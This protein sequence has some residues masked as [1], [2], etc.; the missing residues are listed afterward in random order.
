MNQSIVSDFISEIKQRKS[1]LDIYDIR[2][3]QWLVEIEFLTPI[4]YH[5]RFRKQNINYNAITA[6]DIAQYTFC[7]ASF[8]IQKSFDL[9]PTPKTKVGSKLH[10]ELR[11]INYL[12]SGVAHKSMTDTVNYHRD[13][14]DLIKHS[15]LIYSGHDDSTR[16]QVF[17]KRN[18]YAQPDYIFHSPDNGFFIVEEKYTHASNIDTWDR[19]FNFNNHLMQVAA[20]LYGIEEYQANNGYVLNWLY[21]S[22]DGEH[23]PEP[24]ITGCRIHKVE[25]SDILR[26]KLVNT[27]YNIKAILTHKEQQFDNVNTNKCRSCSVAGIC[28]HKYGKNRTVRIPYDIEVNNAVIGLPNDLYSYTEDIN[29][30]LSEKIGCNICNSLYHPSQLSDCLV[31][32]RPVGI[33]TIADSDGVFKKRIFN[34]TIIKIYTIGDTDKIRSIYP[35]IPYEYVKNEDGSVAHDDDY[36]P[37]VIIMDYTTRMLFVCDTCKKRQAGTIEL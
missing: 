8:A 27:Y 26:D 3:I 31:S 21:R 4:I 34:Y 22:V 37:K 5:H 19:N 28:Q 23:G 24:R 35:I 17:K 11:L 32:M 6:S 20:Y 12:R 18:F 16:T 15:K 13:F 14:F 36:M 30:F 25:R 9:R 1:Y 10:K 7:P 29:N 33:K 2:N